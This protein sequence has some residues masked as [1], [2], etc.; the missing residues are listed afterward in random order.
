MRCAGE[1]KKA[2]AAKKE[3]KEAKAAGK[4]SGKAA[5]GAGELREF[6][7]GLLTPLYVLQ[8]R[9]RWISLLTKTLV[10]LFTL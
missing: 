5:D 10:S 8:K 6:D 9:K 7:P 3:G 1:G 4:Q 2:T